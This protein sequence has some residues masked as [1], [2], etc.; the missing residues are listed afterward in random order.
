MLKSNR[1]SGTTSSFIR[2]LPYF[3]F[4]FCHK[5]LSVAY[6]RLN[7]QTGTECYGTSAADRNTTSGSTGSEYSTSQVTGE[8]FCRTEAFG[9]LT[10]EF[11]RQYLRFPSNRKWLSLDRKWFA[12]PEVASSG[13]DSATPIKQSVKEFSVSTPSPLL[14]ATAELLL[15]I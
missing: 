6:C 3:H 13:P 14:P 10:C 1:K 12:R 9:L 8:L 2:F 11:R 15:Y 7:Q 5:W 4:R